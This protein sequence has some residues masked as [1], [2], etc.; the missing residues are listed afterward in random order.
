MSQW[1]KW[2]WGG[3]GW[4][5]F[6][7]IGGIL[8]FALGALSENVSAAKKYRQDD[9][10]T[11]PGDF[12]VAL[13]VLAAAVMKADGR[14]LKS[15]LEYVKKFFTKQFGE[16]YTNERIL[17]LKEILKQDYPLQEICMQ[18]KQNMDHSS[19]LQLIHFLFGISN[20]DGQVHLT[21][22][23]LI[24]SISSYLGIRTA[25]FESLKAMFY[26]DT[27]SAYKILEIEPHASSEEIKKAYR[28]MAIKYHPDKVTHLGEQFQ[29][30]AKEKFQKLNEAYENIKKERGIN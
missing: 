27:G 7:P 1:S 29:K 8:G 3:L 10:E 26:K 23:D 5:F 13:L 19:R 28:K 14:I 22:V 25:D 4:T 15:E 18:I 21:E 24:G 6:G 20:S 30:A 2:L 17:L 9:N 12:G 11:R 16:N